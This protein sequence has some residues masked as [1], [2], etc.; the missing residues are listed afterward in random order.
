M[1]LLVPNCPMAILE[2]E[3]DHKRDFGW[4][5]WA[6]LTQDKGSKTGEEAAVSLDPE[7]PQGMQ[8]SQRKPQGPIEAPGHL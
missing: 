7:G 4:D 3:R 1:D 6:G 2:E 8:A 5:I